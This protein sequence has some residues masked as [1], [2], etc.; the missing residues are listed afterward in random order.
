MELRTWGGRSH[1]EY[2]GSIESGTKITYGT[3][4]KYNTKV[5]SQQYEDLRKHFLNRIVS[6]GTS[7]TSPEDDS[8]GNWLKENVD[9]RA[10]ASYVA[11]I[12]LEQDYAER[13]E[14]NHIR[15]VK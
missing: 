5:T 13:I 3:K 4:N 6:V 11:A 1:F 8:I 7:R 14:K 2:V 9:K 12:L 10:I 15:I